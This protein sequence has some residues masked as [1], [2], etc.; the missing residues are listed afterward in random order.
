MTFKLTAPKLAPKFV[1]PSLA[2]AALALAGPVFAQET[3]APGTATQPAIIEAPATFV[4]PE[5]YSLLPDWSTVTAD[6]LKG[7]D[8]A[9]PDGGSI[10][11]VS[12]VAL[13]AD[14]AATGLIADIGGFLGLGSHR[15]KLG[16]EQV[17]LYRNADGDLIAH[18][19]LSKEA[20][21]A[22]PEYTAP[23]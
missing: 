12:D 2:A 23:N 17:T 15:V 13:S 1:V 19:M 9:G 11:S 4:P 16:T 10:G 5:G 7:A 20:L 6:K 3:T 8:V 22:L 21:K 18:S 14:G